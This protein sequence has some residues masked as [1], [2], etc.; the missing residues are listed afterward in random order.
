[1]PLPEPVGDGTAGRLHLAM[2]QETLNLAV[3]A[4]GPVWP[5]EAMA[6]GS[7][8]E[9]GVLALEQ[10]ENLPPLT[11]RATPSLVQALNEA[12][13]DL[14]LVEA[15]YPIT[16]YVTFRLTEES[17]TLEASWLQLADRHLAIRSRIV[18]SRRQ[19][20]Q[21]KRELSALGGATVPL[22]EHDELPVSDSNRPRKSRGMFSTLFEGASAVAV[23]IDVAPPLL[24]LAD[25]V[26]HARGWVTEW[27][28]DARLLLLTY[29]ISRAL[30]ER[31]AER[32]Q[33]DRDDAVRD[34]LDA[35]RGRLMYLDGRYSTLRRR[36]FE[37]RHNNRILQWRI[38]ALEVEARA[39]Q[40][41]LEQFDQDRERLM[42]E[43][44][45][46]QARPRPVVDIPEPEPRTDW[47]SRIAR[48]FGVSD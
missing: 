19:E 36:L 30:R 17:S 26:A 8:F 10:R 29:G 44:A 7:L 43:I 28:Q 31:E 9:R 48:L 46:R 12:R 37:L 25:S 40:I 6:L 27:G 13:E 42:R 16:R 41:R 11:G 5:T 21:L 24:R 35:T 15:Q 34:A 23:E 20:E 2:L 1:M 39:M 45:D 32:I 3:E 33:V 22:P 4:A 38:T 47:R 18:E 14:Y